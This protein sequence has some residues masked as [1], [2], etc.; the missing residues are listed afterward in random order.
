MEDPQRIVE[1]DVIKNLI[2]KISIYFNC[3]NNLLIFRK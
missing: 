2:L 1:L 3:V